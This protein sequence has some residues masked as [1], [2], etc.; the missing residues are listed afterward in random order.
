MPDELTTYLKDTQYRDSSNLAARADIHI[1]FGTNKY[2]WPRWMFDQ[3]LKRVPP[4]AAVLELGAGPAWLWRENL[5]RIPE[6]WRVVVSD[7]SPGMVAEQRSALAARE[8]HFTCREIDAQ[9]IPLEDGSVDCVVANHMLYHVA[10]RDRAIGEMR[11]VLKSDGVA[12]A[13]TNGEKHLL[14]LNELVA[15]HAEGYRTFA[16]TFTLENAPG[17]ISSHFGSVETLRYPGDLVVTEWE[18]IMAYVRSMGSLRDRDPS[19]FSA[20]ERE[21][22]DH[23]DRAGALKIQK[24]VGLLVARGL[25]GGVH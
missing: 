13:A 23:V 10:D 6:G 5:D 14:E 9:E 22:R 3:M 24:D 25:A 18:P 7:F 4:H 1:R 21:V 11:R 17:Q 19:V 8:E 12:F 16:E 2:P 15:R 20:I